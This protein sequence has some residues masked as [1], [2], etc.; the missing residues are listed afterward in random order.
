WYTNALERHP[1]SDLSPF[2]A[3]WGSYQTAACFW[4]EVYRI[5]GLRALRGMLAGMRARQPNTAGELVAHAD[6]VLNTDLRPIMSRYGFEPGELDAAPVILSACTLIGTAASEAIAGTS[7]PDRICGLGG[8]D[9][10]TG[11]PGADVLD[12]GAGDDTFNARDG[13]RDVVRG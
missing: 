6:R 9:R 8:R 11:G 12:G 1:Y 7:G 4:L 13:Q 3:D 5:G 10:I 2:T